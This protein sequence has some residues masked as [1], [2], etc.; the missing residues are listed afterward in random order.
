MANSGK[1]EVVND[2][3]IAS[4]AAL[5]EEVWGNGSLNNVTTA[6]D[7]VALSIAAFERTAVFAPFSSKYDAYLKACLAEGGSK[8]Q[9]AQGIGPGAKRAGRIF[10]GREWRGLQLFMG[11]NDNDGVLRKGEGANCAACHVANWTAAEDNV[12][13]PDW[14]PDGSVPPVFSDFTYDNLGIPKNTEYPLSA[15]STPDLGLGVTV[16]DA[17]ENGK[18]KV[19]TLR[20]IALTV[21]YG[22]NGLFKSLAE[23]THFYNTR[24]VARAGW[25][26]PE[27][28]ATM[29][30]AELGNLGMSAGDEKAIVDFL[31]TL[32][33]GYKQ[34]QQQ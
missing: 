26:E 23:I 20:N 19:M 34:H 16:G 30:T 25:S 18:F 28:P 24:D 21:P 10:T 6:Y 31:N 22:H 9:R 4:Y 27:Y 29:N 1:E 2:V 33:D 12:V 5:F 7:Q 8:D 17:G 15:T 11:P 3:K 14:S 13:V 32:T